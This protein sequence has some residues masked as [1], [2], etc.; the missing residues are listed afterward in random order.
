[1]HYLW[2]G[3]PDLAIQRVER[4]VRTGGHPVPPEVV[5]RRYGAGLR[6]F[7]ELYQP[8]SDNWR[9]LDSRDG[10]EARPAAEGAGSRVTTVYDD[11]VWNQMLS[12][13][14]QP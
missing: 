4:R 12:W 10:A 11:H 13:R 6:N 14:R 7:F 9:V 3:S 8:I 1:M 5:R 2:I